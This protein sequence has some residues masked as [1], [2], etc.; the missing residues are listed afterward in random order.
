MYSLNILVS[1]RLTNT[2]NYRICRFEEILSD[3]NREYIINK[4]H[5]IRLKFCRFSLLFNKS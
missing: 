3:K 5:I 4:S 1:V 2:G